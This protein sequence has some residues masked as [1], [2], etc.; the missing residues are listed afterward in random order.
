MLLIVSPQGSVRALYEEAIDLA[1]IGTLTI[2]RASHVEPDA[3]GQW[4][5]DLS[6]V[7][8]PCIGPFHKRY[9]ALAAER[10]WLEGHVLSPVDNP[11]S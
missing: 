8:G 6:P 9:E 11:T 10:R 1:A 7:H 5:A 2:C 4:F 3:H